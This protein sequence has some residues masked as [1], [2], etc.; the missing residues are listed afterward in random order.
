MRLMMA[1]HGHDLWH[2]L[3][4]KTLYDICDIIAG[5]PCGFTTAESAED[6]SA[7]GDGGLFL[8]HQSNLVHEQIEHLEEVI[9]D[10][11]GDIEAFAEDYDVFEI[12]PE[13]VDDE[14]MPR[15]AIRLKLV[16][17]Q[18]KLKIERARMLDEAVS[19][20]ILAEELR[21][22]DRKID[23]EGIRAEF[24]VSN[25]AVDRWP[26]GLAGVG[27]IYLGVSYVKFMLDSI[28]LK[29]R[30]PAKSEMS[31]Y[32]DLV[33]EDVRNG[34]RDTLVRIKAKLQP[35]IACAVGYASA[36]PEL[37]SEISKKISLKRYASDAMSDYM[38]GTAI[39]RLIRDIDIKKEDAAVS[40]STMLA[41]LASIAGASD[42]FNSDSK[43]L[44]ELATVEKLAAMNDESRA[45]YLS[46]VGHAIAP[47]AAP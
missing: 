26:P 12:E 7:N 10:L 34:D 43:G 1:K 42:K 20:A 3:S 4:T 36:T 31:V 17:R 8:L 35:T 13:D 14:K 47:P 11:G 46:E 40:M 15:N 39:A 33:V 23:D 29:C 44:A 19:N 32:L 30:V 21:P 5:K 28:G 9:T 16:G 2:V 18:L 6:V 25:S 37:S 24:P 45:Y 38:T 22:D 27:V 41:N